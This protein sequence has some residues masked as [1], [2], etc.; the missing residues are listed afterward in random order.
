MVQD[1]H[2]I[3]HGKDT[4]SDF[5][6]ALI[7]D[8]KIHNRAKLFKLTQRRQISAN[9]YWELIIGSSRFKIASRKSQ[10]LLQ[11]AIL[12]EGLI[13]SV[14]LK[15]LCS[16]PLISFLL[17]D[18]SYQLAGY[19]AWFGRFIET[20]IVFRDNLL[21]L[22]SIQDALLLRILQY[23]PPRLPY[24]LGVHLI[25]P[26]E[27]NVSKFLKFKYLL[28]GIPVNK[29]LVLS[30]YFSTKLPPFPTKLFSS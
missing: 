7:H 22:V 11:S 4:L 21:V 18:C 27:N 30:V 20:T 16:S 3:T 23:K 9:G 14:V 25:P 8:H 26:P 12:L 1:S 13:A 17:S 15:S 10:W 5:W 2:H 24:S 6:K 19:R 28:V 29:S